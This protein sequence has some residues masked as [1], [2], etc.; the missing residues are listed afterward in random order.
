MVWISGRSGASC[1]YHS[2]DSSS[3]CSSNRSSP[4]A[5][6]DNSSLI[7]CQ[8]VTLTLLSA[9]RG[10]PKRTTTTTSHAPPLS[11]R[12]GDDVTAVIT[13]GALR[14]CCT[15]VAM[16]GALLTSQLPRQRA[17]LLRYQWEATEHMS[18]HLRYIAAH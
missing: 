1:V 16:R 13:Y 3:S 2:S 17:D 14:Y 9:V 7:K 18:G 6:H 10:L 8:A 5:L 15:L 11:A 4:A 12:A